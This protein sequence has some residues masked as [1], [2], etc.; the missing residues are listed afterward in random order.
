MD[1]RFRQARTILFAT[2]G[3]GISVGLAL[4]RH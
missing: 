2:V 3:G 1:G 4:Y